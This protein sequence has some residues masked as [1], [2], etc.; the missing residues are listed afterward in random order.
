MEVGQSWRASGTQDEISNICLLW[1]MTE[2]CRF[3]LGAMRQ[4]LCLFAELTVPSWINIGSKGPRVLTGRFCSP[5]QHSDTSIVHCWCVVCP[6][7]KVLMR[8]LTEEQ[9]EE[10]Q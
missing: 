10:E 4:L 9:I 7:V 8:S 1:V 6:P 3:W 2:Q 5:L